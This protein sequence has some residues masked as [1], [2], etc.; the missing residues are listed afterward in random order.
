MLNC[1]E[2]K[3]YVGLIVNRDRLGTTVKIWKPNCAWNLFFQIKMQNSAP[4]F[5]PVQSWINEKM[6]KNILSHFIFPS[7]LQSGFS[8]DM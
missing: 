2:A 5:P 7:Y 3:I 6:L 8:H 4:V 1:D